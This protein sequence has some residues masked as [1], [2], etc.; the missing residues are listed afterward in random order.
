MILAL[1]H[2]LRKYDS[3]SDKGVTLADTVAHTLAYADD[4]ALANDINDTGIEKNTEKVSVSSISA[5]VSEDGDMRF[6]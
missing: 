5:G 4:I 6:N 3:T 1:E 2:I